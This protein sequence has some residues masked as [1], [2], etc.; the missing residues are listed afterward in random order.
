MFKDKFNS[1]VYNA[2]CRVEDGI[3]RCTSPKIENSLHEILFSHKF[4][5]KI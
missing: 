3:G 1:A 5:P 2:T 4:Y